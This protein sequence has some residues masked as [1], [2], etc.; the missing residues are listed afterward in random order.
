MNTKRFDIGDCVIV[1]ATILSDRQG[2]TGEEKI[3]IKS[4]F[5]EPKTGQ[6]VGI[7]RLQEGRVSDCVYGG[8]NEPY[9]DGHPC[10]DVRKTI[11]V[12]LV[13]FGKINKT[14]MVADEDISLD[15]DGKA[16]GYRA[17]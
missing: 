7:S 6:V 5:S 14:V 13:R 17:N 3:T 9:E 11:P 12:W 10:L 8:Y 1:R 16:V 4:E 15:K 2:E